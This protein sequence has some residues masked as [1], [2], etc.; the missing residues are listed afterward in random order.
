MSDKLDSCIA[1]LG[2]TDPKYDRKEL[3]AWH[4]KRTEGTCQW[5]LNDGVFQRWKD[6][7]V[8]EQPLIWICG[9]S[10]TGKT[11][12]AIF[13]SEH[14]EQTYP[15]YE[16]AWVLYYFCD[17]RYNNRNTAASILK[18]FIWQ[19]HKKQKDLAKIL[20]EEYRTQREALLQPHSIEPL[21]SIFQSMV[22]DS[23]A[24]R[25]FCIIDGVDHCQESNLAHFL[26]KLN[27]DVARHNERQSVSDNGNVQNRHSD[28]PAE[29]DVQPRLV[30][31]LRMIILSCENPS[32]IAEELSPFRLT[33]SNDQQQTGK[34]DL[35]RHTEA[36]ISAS[37]L[38]SKISN[39]ETTE[40]ITNALGDRA[41]QS[42]EWIGLAIE[43]LMTMK[44]NQIKK[45]LAHIP[46]NVEDMLVQ[47]LLAVPSR[48]RPHVAAILKWI[49]LAV[50][51][52]STLE[53]TKAVKYSLKTPFSKRSLKKALAVCH[54][55]VRRQDKQV[56]LAQQS[57][58]E[59]LFQE[60]SPL[61]QEEHL[62]DFV[63][64]TSDAHS[65]LA[66]VCIAY[67]QDSANLGKSRRVRLKP[68]DELKSDDATFL[69]KHPFLEYAIVH[70]PNH[71]KQ[72]N[73]KKTDYGVAFFKNDS[74]RRRLWWESYW[75]SLRQTF[76]WKWTAPGKFSL[77]HLAA[78]FDIV[79]LALYV[80]REGRV[81]DLLGAQDHLGM[82]PINWATE[83]SQVEMVKFL[84]E[85]GEFDDET[86]R[87]AARTG[88]AAIIAMLLNNKE[89]ILRTPKTPGSPSSPQ[90]PSSPFQSLRQATLR[91]V[92][93]FSKKMD[94]ANNE[95]PSP[96]SP[97]IKGYGKATS[98]TPL[99]I[100]A[101]CGHDEAIEAFVQAGEDVE[102]ST[103]G[104][105]TPLHN[106]AWFGRVSTV[107]RL[108]AVGADSKAGTKEQLT[109]LHC[110]VKNS[111]PAVVR[112][113]LN[114]RV[115]DIEAEDQFGLT[116][117][118]MAC[119][120]NNID[121]M[122]I[123]HD[124]GASIERKMKQ[125]FTPLVWACINGQAKV[126]ELLLKRGA[127]I[128]AKWI[129]VY[130]EAGKKVEL[131]PVGLAKA[132]R[133][134]DIARL[135]ER[136]GATDA[137]PLAS[138]ETKALPPADTGG[139]EY[140]VPDVPDIV[141]VQ[142]ED[143]ID[144]GIDDILDAGE[145][146]SLAESDGE[147]DAGSDFGGDVTRSRK[148]SASSIP[149]DCPAR[150]QSSLALS[151]LGIHEEI[152]SDVKDVAV[153]DEEA[154]CREIYVIS[155]KENVAAA[156]GDSIE[157]N[158][159]NELAPEADLD[160]QSPIEGLRR[161]QYQTV[162]GEEVLAEPADGF[163]VD[164]RSN[165]VSK[166]LS[167]LSTRFGRFVPKKAANRTGSAASDDKSAPHEAKN[168]SPK[169]AAADGGERL[170]REAATAVA[171]PVKADVGALGRFGPKRIFSWK[172]DGSVEIGQTTFPAS[173][174]IGDPLNTQVNNP[175]APNLPHSDELQN[176]TD[177]K[178]RSNAAN[179]LTSD[180]ASQPGRFSAKKVFS[181]K[182]ASGNRGTSTVA[183]QSAL[184]IA[185][186]GTELGCGPGQNV[187]IPDENYGQ[188]L[189]DTPALGNMSASG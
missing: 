97:D 83:R 63:F 9:R 88:E 112:C 177:D 22:N 120:S 109:P 78:F 187:S 134:E 170:D 20:Y 69:R 74:T 156:G 188:A 6:E 46:D 155:A 41:D 164:H 169:T 94:R 108:I 117:F 105:W 28:S 174:E 98:E 16:D 36:K 184:E 14:L 1:D 125:G 57:V 66:N 157:P 27:S 80:E 82:K 159:Q 149:E 96:F 70:W 77:L 143:A 76:A 141:P 121:I 119:K 7:E 26:N 136:F 53:L 101:T 171:N 75:I 31:E 138:D 111:K 84:L 124:Y 133:H 55:L 64:E 135:V 4:H 60:Q 130:T 38:D 116:P 181:L 51:P 81:Q 129:Q 72:G 154:E 32:C 147:S 114:Q 189:D 110:A 186:K 176:T 17:R 127:D 180:S 179:G 166:P 160:S 79:P 106:A 62:K 163:S 12:L 56:I 102:S 95:K 50:R 100:A 153:R 59:L 37:G 183:P 122:E 54:G 18:G 90:T 185:E 42:F 168:G 150:G 5:I 8:P 162:L 15:T 85:R 178:T 68:G 167:L 11:T 99:H 172:K 145:S 140:N 3:I 10:G 115:V 47:T 93:D 2:Q 44:E 103:E 24:K 126:A 71:A 61:R 48:Q 39:K 52:L 132:Y 89:K 113:L 123:L 144:D 87:Q 92:S 30:T 104:G 58:Y 29:A 86:L 128:N 65:E 173:E 21:W 158:E 131:G 151:G 91:S 161:T 107:N 67:L 33:P 23:K 49:A 146:E 40:L 118:H 152:D 139:E 148:Q 142:Q 137:G 45:C 25:I 35:R 13:I 43:K 34:S 182:T 175:K 19:L 165:S 73:L